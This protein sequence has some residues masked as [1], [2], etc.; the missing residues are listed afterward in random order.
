MVDL[1][2]PLDD[3]VARLRPIEPSHHE[4]GLAV[5]RRQVRGSDP[6]DDL[7]G[8]RQTRTKREL[9]GTVP[10]RLSSTGQCSSTVRTK[11]A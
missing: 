8:T 11:C 6:A 2:P 4:R 5:E 7:D 1:A 9:T 10:V 3:P